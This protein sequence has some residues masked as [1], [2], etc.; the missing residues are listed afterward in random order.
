MNTSKAA[1]MFHYLDKTEERFCKFLNRA[2][3]RPYI[4]SSFS[5]I[6]RLG[7]GV[8]WYVLILSLPLFYGLAA[9]PIMM[10]MASTGLLGVL[11]Y[12]VLKNKLVRQ[13]PFITHSN[14]K[15]GT[16]PLDEYSFPSGHTLHAV[17]FSS[18]LIAYY[19]EWAVLVIPFTILIGLSRPVLG[20]HYPSDVIVGAF[21]GWSLSAVSLTLFQFPV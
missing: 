15:L 3:Y 17:C 9:L 12:K 8:F 19:P 14:I 10:Q 2:S 5:T 11:I 13:R 4:N 6:S 16:A 1:P 20:L 21:I 18:I 7:N